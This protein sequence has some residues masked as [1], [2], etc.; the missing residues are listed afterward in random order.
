MFFD[1]RDN[2][3]RGDGI[4]DYLKALLKKVKNKVMLIWDNAPWHKAQNVKDFL[5]TEEGSRI[6]LANI[7]PYSPELNPD[8]FVWANLKRV[9]I[10]N[11]MAKN[12]K[13]LKNI[14]QKGME[15][16]QSSVELVKSFFNRSNYF[17]YNTN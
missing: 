7:P 9:Q 12:I 6:W 13:E 15:K 14:A 17:D 8:E 16:I 11:A 4:I 1:I 2:S 10:P 5:N 3:F